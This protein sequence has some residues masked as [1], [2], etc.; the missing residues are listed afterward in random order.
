MSQLRP[1]SL[2]T[3]KV[4]RSWKKVIYRNKLSPGRGQTKPFSW[5]SPRPLTILPKCR[6]ASLGTS[7]S[8]TCCCQLLLMSAACLEISLTWHALRHWGDSHAHGRDSPTRI[9][10]QSRPVKPIGHAT[11]DIFRFVVCWLSLANRR[12]LRP[13]TTASCQTMFI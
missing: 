10:T 4:I 2:P 1:L 8:T 6:G 12:S 5:L 13:G 7:L 11:N 3:M 9:Q